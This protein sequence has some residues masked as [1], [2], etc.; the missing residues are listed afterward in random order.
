MIEGLEAQLALDTAQLGWWQYD[1]R[2]R[3]ASGD[4]RYKESFDITGDETL[5]RK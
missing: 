5:P 1:P 2:R 4:A 3:V